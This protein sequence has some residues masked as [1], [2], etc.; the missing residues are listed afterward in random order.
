[1]STTHLEKAYLEA[2][3]VDY[4]IRLELIPNTLRTKKKWRV[5]KGSK[6]T[7][8]KRSQTNYYDLIVGYVARLVAVV[9]T[10]VF[11]HTFLSLYVST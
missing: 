2:P 10:V 3:G 6:Y 8:I 1:M 9:A 5:Q 7:P 4:E 11:A